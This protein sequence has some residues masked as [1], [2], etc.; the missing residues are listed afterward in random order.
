MSTELK[1]AEVTASERFSNMVVKEFTG[2]SGA[3]QLTAFQ[4]RLAGNYFIGVDLALKTAEA[5]RLKKSEKYRDPVPVTWENV[6][7]N[8]LAVNVVSSARMSLDPVLPNHIH[9]VPYKN[10]TTKK[11]D[12]GFIP[13]YRGKEIIARKYGF[14]PPDDVIVEVVCENDLFKPYKKDKN[15]Q[16]ES[17]EFTVTNPFDRGDIV[18]GFYYHVYNETPSA[19]KLMFYNINDILKRK[20]EYASAEFWGGEKDEWKD[21]NKTGK[22]TK[23]E[24]WYSEM[25]W[26]TLVRAAY[27]AITIDSQ[28]IDDDFIRLTEQE[29]EH[30]LALSEFQGDDADTKANKETIDIQ[31]AHEVK[32]EKPEPKQEPKEDVK[33]KAE[34]KIEQPQMQF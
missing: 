11:Y 34:S 12:I 16:I 14:N 2:K 13:G 6:N 20:P 28:K 30:N 21:G 22:K 9:M 7:M 4:K 18:G 3:V 26:K 15:N 29:A 33:P 19:N 17:Y 10:S 31:E 32:E 24:G 27:G 8:T 1:K 5:N 23:V 25:V